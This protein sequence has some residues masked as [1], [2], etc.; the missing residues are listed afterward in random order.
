MGGAWQ[1][2]PECGMA[3]RIPVGPGKETST[4]SLMT[5]GYDPKA[6]AWSPFHGAQYAVIESLA[7][8]LARN[9]FV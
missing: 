9:N 4:V 6:A 8:V 1:S 3:A 5:M 7:K 2:T